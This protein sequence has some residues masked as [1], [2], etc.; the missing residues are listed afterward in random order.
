MTGLRRILFA[1]L[2][3]AFRLLAWAPLWVGR[4]FD[5]LADRCEELA[6]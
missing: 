4:G 2:A 6:R 5:W 1:L 3:A